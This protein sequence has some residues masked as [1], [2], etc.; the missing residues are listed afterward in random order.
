MTV[1]R[2]KQPLILV[3]DPDVDTLTSL[4]FILDGEGYLVA[5]VHPTIDA[6]KGV[7]E[8]KPDLVIAGQ[9]AFD[10]N[11]MD[12]VRKIREISPDTRILL[13]VDPGDQL[14]SS[15]AKRSGA[16]QLVFKPYTRVKVLEGVGALLPV[17]HR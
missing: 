17:G 10:W 15:K 6:L 1:L 9:E 13:L 16:D 5:T 7:V 3:V 4:Y 14:G 12:L 11:G 2:D 8:Q